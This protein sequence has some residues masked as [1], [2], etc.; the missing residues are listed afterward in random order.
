MVENL[1]EFFIFTALVLGL[2]TSF[3]C[4]GMCGPIALS[5]GIGKGYRISFLSK[6]M[7]YQ[8]GRV[9]TYSTLG[10]L[11]G[12]VGGF[13]LGEYQQYLSIFLGLVM[14]STVLLSKRSMQPNLPFLQ[15]PLLWLKK[16]MANLLGKNAPQS[17]YTIGILNGFLPCGA[18][19]I[20]L[21]GSLATA[22]PINGAL[23]ML[24]FG[25][26]TIPLMFL[27][28]LMGNQISL[29]TRNKISKIFPYIVF[30]LGVLFILR[31]LSLD[32]PYISPAAESLN[33]A[34]DKCCH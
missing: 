24:F 5:L 25:L 20:A 15:K 23:F 32:I 29:A 2:G 13:S 9:T 11:L 31:G 19:Y 4:I 27:V 8:L 1:Q 10:F 7:L 34:A 30:L 12:L 6:N 28:V 33:P 14:I 18:V 21:A 26:G 17:L 22:S 16:Q 3:H